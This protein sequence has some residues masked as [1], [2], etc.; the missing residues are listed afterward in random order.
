[1]LGYMCDCWSS[2]LTSSMPASALAKDRAA[3]AVLDGLVALV[4]VGSAK[5]LESRGSGAEGSSP[6]P[7]ELLVVDA[8]SSMGA[9]PP[10]DCASFTTSRVICSA[11]T[12]CRS[13]V[14]ARGSLSEGRSLREENMGR[15]RRGRGRPAVPADQ[16]RRSESIHLVSDVKRRHKE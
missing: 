16:G 4:V 11:I 14:A 12:M 7:A 13:V 3:L 6:L 2:L 8:V 15:N 10:T 5:G 1:M 9:G